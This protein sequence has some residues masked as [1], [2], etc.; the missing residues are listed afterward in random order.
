MIHVDDMRHFMRGEIV[1]HERRRE[2]QAPREIEPAGRGARPPAAHRVAQHHA[3]RLD[4]E[5]LGMPRHRS[6]E[7]LARLAL[8]EIGDATRYMRPLAGN[9]DERSALARFEPDATALA[10][11]VHDAMIDAAEWRHRAR[12]ERDGFRQTRKP[13]A[14]PCGV[15]LGKFARRFDR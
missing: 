14:N 10:R 9:A 6:F 4:A 2:N 11:P 12:L 7:I 8:E 15:A 5:L 3:A 1:E 13:R